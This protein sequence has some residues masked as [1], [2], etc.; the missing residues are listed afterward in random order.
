MGKL[1]GFFFLPE[2]IYPSKLS[3]TC[4]S[5]SAWWDHFPKTVWSQYA[6]LGQRHFFLPVSSPGGPIWTLKNRVT[7]VWAG[8]ANSPHTYIICMGES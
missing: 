3:S 7:L 1:Q 2:S 8:D 5:L 6:D 4:S